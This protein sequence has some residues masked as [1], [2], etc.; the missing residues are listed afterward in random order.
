VGEECANTPEVARVAG[1]IRTH[2]DW[3]RT[4]RFR[5]P[6]VALTYGIP[7]QWMFEATPTAAGFNYDEAISGYHRTLL[8]SGT[9]P[10]VIMSGADLSHYRVIFSPYTPVLDD[11]TRRR[12]QDFVERGGTWVLGPL[13]AHRTGEATAK[14][15]AC[16]GADFQHWLGVHVRH[17]LPPGSVTRLSSDRGSSGCR[18][19][20]DA[21]QPDSPQKVL[22]TYS[23]GP[24]DGMAAVVEC[25]IGTGR[26]ILLGT[27]P[28][29]SWL[30]AFLR[31]LVPSG[32]VEAT[33]GVV[34]AQ[35]VD[36]GGRPAG[37]IVINTKDSTTHFRLPG[38]DR[39][40]IGAYGVLI[41]PEK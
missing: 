19:W 40:S 32:G 12:F 35:R 37:F 10:D 13:S 30:R 20:C 41:Q 4:T 23:C 34:A 11:A 31:G 16:Y 39:Q 1:E 8:E 2:A 25:P 21:Y 24:L 14:R 3:L 22:A 9:V 28:D 15:D 38:A 36:A 18:W 6:E 26:V 33:P 5:Q 27:Q 7:A 17:R 29:E